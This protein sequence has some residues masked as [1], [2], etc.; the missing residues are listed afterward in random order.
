MY[1]QYGTVE[2]GRR[3]V[4]KKKTEELT[5]WK[6][7]SDEEGKGGKKEREKGN[8]VQLDI[9]LLLLNKP[10]SP[11]PGDGGLRSAS[12]HLVFWMHFVPGLCWAESRGCLF[13]LIENRGRGA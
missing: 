11:W 3:S 6:G 5:T 7:S 4:T 9:R 2:R 13:W 8:L 1:V 12:G 10:T